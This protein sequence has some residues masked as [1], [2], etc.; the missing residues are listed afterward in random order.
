VLIGTIAP[1]VDLSKH[2]AEVS[3]I[4]PLADAL[5]SIR[6]P[7]SS[8]TTIRAT[9][10]WASCLGPEERGEAWFVLW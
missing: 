7:I 2:W 10:R 1:A 4:T 9:L 6:P 3:R 8:F 5:Q